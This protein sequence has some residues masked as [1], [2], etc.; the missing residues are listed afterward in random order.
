MLYT[1]L[2]SVSLEKGW[3]GIKNTK[4]L[5]DYQWVYVNHYLT[6]DRVVHTYLF[7]I[8]FFLAL[9]LFFS[10]WAIVSCSKWIL[11]LQDQRMWLNVVPLWIFYQEFL[12]S[13]TTAWKDGI[14]SRISKD[15]K[16][17]FLHHQ[18]RQPSISV[19]KINK[20]ERY[21]RNINIMHHQNTEQSQNHHKK[22]WV[23]L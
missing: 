2:G 22:I 3:A 19:W 9:G 23:C 4:G 7:L 16:F 15:H 21:T 12:R 10:F 18:P 14:L 13:M 1:W 6:K 17:I 11:L 5:Q 8:G 20:Q